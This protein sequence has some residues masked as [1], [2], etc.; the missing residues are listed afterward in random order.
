MTQTVSSRRAGPRKLSGR[1]DRRKR[2]ARGGG[3][4]ASPAG[5]STL[6]PVLL[7]T[8]APP[9]L[10]GLERRRGRLLELLGDAVHVVRVLEE[11]L[12]Q[13][14]ERVAA[15]GAR[16]QVG[17]V[18][19]EGLR[20]RERRRRLLEELVRIEL[21]VD[22]LVRRREAALLDPDLGRLRRRQV[23]DQGPRGR[24]VLEH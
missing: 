11:V 15:E 22:V 17:H 8:P 23:L 14:E 19:A 6:T 18:E 13:R 21:G 10:R 12:Q 7:T 9:L 2:L 3:G 5:N 16:H 1:R 24:V 20:V 4:G